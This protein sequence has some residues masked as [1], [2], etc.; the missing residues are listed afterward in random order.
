MNFLGL[1]SFMIGYHLLIEIIGLHGKQRPCL[2]DVYSFWDVIIIIAF[3]IMIFCLGKYSK[4]KI[5]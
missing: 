1:W 2:N 5:K 3:I 4:F